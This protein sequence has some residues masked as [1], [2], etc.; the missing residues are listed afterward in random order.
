[1]KSSANFYIEQLGLTAHV[2]GGAFK[3][4]Y[5]S[6][7]VLPEHVLT[8]E[9][10]G[11]RNAM[12]SIYFLLKY[13][14]FSAFH[15][16]ASDELW[17]FYDGEPLCIYEI[18]KE[19]ILTRHLLGKN[20]A[21]GESLVVCITAGSWFGSRVEETDGYTLCGCSVAPGFDFEDFELA[22][23]ITLKLQYPQHGNIIEALT[24]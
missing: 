2:E 5:R 3:E 18:N 20:I 7:L 8:P 14:D 17:H 1:M 22:D 4:I 16:I 10:K 23:R 21:A 6:P 9:H 15:R 12:T 24:R 19:G 13:G 11:N